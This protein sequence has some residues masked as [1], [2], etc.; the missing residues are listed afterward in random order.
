MA[1][2]EKPRFSILLYSN[3][4]AVRDTMRLALGRRPAPDLGS[5]R[6]IEASNAHEVMST[7]DAG[8]VDV[9]LLDGEAWP[10][11]GMAIARQVRDEIADPPATCVI[12]A[13]KVDAWLATWSQA[14]AY[15]A[16]PLN[17]VETA[18]TIGN[19]LR[20]RVARTPIPH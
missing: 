12:L 15:I 17:P 7:I 5:V 16:H 1:S 2:I 6:F 10:T 8:G 4:A 19:L 20:Q 11:G 14:D 13:R 9:L 3:D 18:H